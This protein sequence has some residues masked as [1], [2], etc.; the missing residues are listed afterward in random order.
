[1]C[2]ICS[3]SNHRRRHVHTLER[4]HTHTRPPTRRDLTLDQN[5]NYHILE[6]MLATLYEQHF[7]L[8]TVRCNKYKH[9]KE[10]W[11][12]TGI[13]HSIKYRDKLYCKLKQTAPTDADFSI[14]SVN[15]NAYKKILSK[16]IQ[17]A[18]RSYYANLFEKS[19]TSTKDTW[20]AIRRIV[21]SNSN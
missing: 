8:N 13:L 11:I 17:N 15:V 9:K 6:N 14:L 19:K 16:T 7:S 21:N 10:N 1:M 20:A 4:I 2:Q 18:N 5:V 3:R 12:T